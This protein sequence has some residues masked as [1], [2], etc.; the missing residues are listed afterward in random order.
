[1]TAQLEDGYCSI[2]VGNHGLIT[3]ARFVA[4]NYIHS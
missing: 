3:I 1:L 2:T 4:K